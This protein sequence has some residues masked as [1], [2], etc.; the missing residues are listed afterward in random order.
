MVALGYSGKL[1]DLF[2]IKSNL[3][4]LKATLSGGS[5]KIIKRSWQIF[6]R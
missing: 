6:Y 5:H 2:T 1:S 4:F 3:K